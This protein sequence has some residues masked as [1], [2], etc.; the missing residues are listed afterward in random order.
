MDAHL[1][2]C[3]GRHKGVAKRRSVSPKKSLINLL[4]RN[5][6]L[7]LLKAGKRPRLERLN[8]HGDFAKQFAQLFCPRARVPVAFE[9]RQAAMDF[10]EGDAITPIV[11]AIGA[12]R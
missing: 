11:S 10:V 5:E 12:E 7:K 8:G 6:I 9:P 1:R 2:D 4:R 3:N